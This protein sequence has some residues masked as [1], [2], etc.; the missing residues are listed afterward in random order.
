MLWKFCDGKRI[1]MEWKIEE[2]TFGRE[3]R[4][5]KNAEINWKEN[6]EAKNPENTLMIKTWRLI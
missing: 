6:K 5:L 2:E 1:L 3:V 4:R